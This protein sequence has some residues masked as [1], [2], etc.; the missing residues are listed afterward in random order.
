LRFALH[1]RSVIRRHRQLLW[2]FIAA[3]TTDVE[4]RAAA[5]TPKYVHWQGVALNEAHK[6]IALAVG[7]ACR[8]HFVSAVGHGHTSGHTPGTSVRVLWVLRFRSLHRPPGITDDADEVT[9]RL[10]HMGVLAAL[11]LAVG[12][13]RRVRSGSGLVLSVRRSRANG[14]EHAR[15]LCKV[16]AALSH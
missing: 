14:P 9:A 13:D 7:T 10:R 2:W 5:G 15:Q 4:L 3:E 16:V 11:L 1:L 8:R 12:A 6:D